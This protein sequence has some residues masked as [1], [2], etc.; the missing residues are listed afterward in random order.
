MGEAP[1]K[2]W[3]KLIGGSTVDFG[4]S[5]STALDGS[6][7]VVGYTD[8]NL[9]GQTISGSYDAF[10][11][12]LNSDGSREWTRLV[13]GSIKDFGHSVTTGKDGFIYIAGTTYSSIDGQPFGG[14]KDAFVTK[15][16]TDGSR[17]WTRLVGGSSD[18]WANS[19]GAGIDG[20]I[21]ITGVTLSPSLDQQLVNGTS[22]AF[23]TKFNVDGSKLWTKLIGSSADDG[24]MSVSIAS[25][26]SIYVV[27]S[28]R[29][30]LD[31]QI[32]NKLPGD[33][34][35][36][37]GFVAK[38]N[39]DGT[40]AWTRL[41]GGVSNDHGT[42]VA[43]AFDGSVYLAGSTY[44]D[45]DKQVNSGM[46]DGFIV[47]FNAN[48]DK[49][50]SKLIGQESYDYLKSISAASDGSIYV[51]ATTDSPVDLL[52]T[53]SGKGYSLIAK[54]DANGEKMWSQLA[55]ETPGVH[56]RSASL[57]SDGS[58]FIA[59]A[60]DGYY[61]DG[62]VNN[63]SYD[64]FV[65]KFNSDG[66]SSNKGYSLVP[67][68][69]NV[70]E[71]S[72][73]SISVLTANVSSGSIL[74]WSVNGLGISAAD[75][76]NGE[77]T[78]SGSV[79]IDGKLSFSL[80]IANDLTTEGVETPQ[81]KLFS[82]AART[83][84]VGSTASVSIS[85]TSITLA[86]T[87]SLTP[88][89]SSINEGGTLTTSISTTGVI[90][91]TTLYYGLSGTGIT[92]SD[93]SSG[94]LTGQ[95]T[96]GTNG[97]ASLSHTLS[98]DL[99]TEGS[100]TLQIKLFS[101]AAR[102]IQVGSTASVSIS[103][104]SITPAPTYSLT[105]SASSINEGGTL[106]TT[107]STTGVTSGTT[108]YYSL[109]GTGI[110][111][112]DFSSGALT[113]L[114]VVATDGKYSFT[115]TAVND[116]ATEGDETLQIKLFTD[117][118][119]TVQVGPTANVTIKDNSLTPVKPTQKVYTEKS[120]ITYKSTSIATLPLLYTTSSS[121][122]NLSGLTLNVHYNSSIL[123]PSVANNGVSGQVP[124]AIAT[125]TILP[126][127]N[128]ADGDPLTDKIVQL[129]W[130]TFDNS[131]PNKTLPAP[132]AAVSFNT[133]SIKNDPLTG[134]PFTTT[135]RYTASEKASGYDFLTGSTTFKAQQFNLDVDGDGKVTALGD[136]L[137]VIRKL[138]GPAFAGN[139]LT[140]KA[141]SPE[142]TR[143]TSEIHDF[144]QQGIDA[145]LLDVD[146]DKKTTA[147]GD[148]LMVIRR[149]FGP[150]FDGAALTNKA[151]SPDSPYFGQSTDFMSVA[152]N[153]DS[154][155]TAFI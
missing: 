79:G 13:G 52:S 117:S 5:V 43:T 97:T 54:Y 111:A 138:F 104:T 51:A 67:S 92:T 109:S 41:V 136:G 88:S 123:T 58:F 2:A 139:A 62:Q 153:I 118:A 93:F 155:K 119:L 108:L 8:G 46:S 66:S 36:S 90:S 39:S 80:T 56:L 144:I 4:D 98:N 72:T 112:A 10:I 126:D 64:A 95:V 149:L 75:F 73:L 129:L 150:A 29:G 42:S 68:V 132:L 110:T 120:E 3:T 124:A 33:L 105:P 14:K 70:D 60:T 143:T 116:L 113:G 37:D 24:A 50:W 19:V 59:G 99:T 103:D 35:N 131:F 47:K 1:T 148:G 128:N 147:L 22:D 17:V 69:L 34:N 141:I 85:D 137:M 63:D 152:L 121:D 94:A 76:T 77:L 140:Y 102:T 86:P 154:L 96:F 142:A 11:A 83:I 31:Q 89:A 134:Q 48:G 23:V 130:A 151:I 61:L 32:H 71:G 9:H 107:L 133:S 38:F 30:N 12:K 115:H 91:G 101:D 20:S 16:N 49:T 78:G 44:G 81:I 15:F 146:K 84:Q 18:D 6:I 135:V 87:Y 100:E 125:T 145:D 28:T 45:L 27:G 40:K 106:T 57:A 26:G 55:I 127:T 65:V 53:F 25:D 114:G 82:D 122:A 21:Y 74:Y 7:Y